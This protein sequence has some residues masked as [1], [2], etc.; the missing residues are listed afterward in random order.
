M[1]G[2]GSYAFLWQQSDR[3]D[4]PLSLIEVFAA[5]R[6]LGVDL[7]QICDY[8]PLE[9]MTSRELADAAAAARDL[10]ITVEL[11][12]RGVEPLRLA[13]F[14]GLAAIFGARLVRSMLPAGDL[15]EAERSLREALPAY[16]KAGVDLALETYEQ[17]AT[18]D[19]IGLIETIGSERL[20]ICLD[21]A[22]VVARLENPRQTVE[23]TA[24]YVRNVH[25][26]D[27][28]FTRRLGWVGFTYSGAP[29]GGGL[30]DYDHLLTTVRPRERGI[31]EIVEHWLPWQGDAETT[32]RAERD[33]TRTAVEFL[34]SAQ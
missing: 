16:E 6:A 7:F 28:G 20:G 33:W 3:V 18:A 21:P 27:F 26:K 10:G 22:N 11:G 9:T 17:V 8:A 32:V 1:I 34:R 25:A 19:Q 14:L 12:T 31:N 13:R 23:Q 4:E 15:R 2:L 24:P 29:M 5:T 30:H